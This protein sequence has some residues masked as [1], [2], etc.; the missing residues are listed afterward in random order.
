MTTAPKLMVSFLFVLVSILHY[1]GAERGCVFGNAAR[2]VL[3]PFSNFC[4]VTVCDVIGIE[5]RGS[6]KKKII[7]ELCAFQKFNSMK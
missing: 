3:Y 2:T 1:E 5:K 7:F 6:L 4:G